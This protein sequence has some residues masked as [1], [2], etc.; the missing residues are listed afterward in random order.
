MSQ[1]VINVPTARS[2]RDIPQPVKPRAMSRGGR[3]RFAA[4]ILRTTTMIAVA[5]ALGWG[6]WAV[7]AT[8]RENSPGV[9]AAERVPVKRLEL[10]T[11]AE[12]VLDRDPDWLVRTLALPKRASLM[13][14]DLLALRARVLADGQVLTAS[15]TRKF[16]D[17]LVVQVTERMPVA[18]VLADAG[19]ER[20]TLLVA[21]DGV[22][23]AGTG[24]DTAM[25]ATLPWLDGMTLARKGGVFQPVAGMDAVSALLAAA[26]TYAAHLYSAWA[27]VSLA[28]LDS[29]RE[30]EVHTRA[31]QD[32]TMVF[33]ADTDYFRQL[34][35]LNFMWEN[36]ANRPGAQARVDLSLGR[37]VP[38][39]VSESAAP[40]V[41]APGAAVRAEQK[42]APAPAWLKFSFSS[43]PQ[44][45]T[46]REL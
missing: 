38:V 45:N 14:L 41:S 43:S 32:V 39:M 16:P 15:L 4:A 37:Q 19:G 2:W 1:P 26:Q 17:C 18:R 8:L 33:N 12:G 20:K 30:L 35:R 34:A 42:P 23:F 10:K 31:P 5:L 11:N 22:V 7:V 9:S 3:W 27:V 24:Y 6:A 46:Q 13:E 44:P 29:D 36:L 25:L 28:R 21:R 40:A